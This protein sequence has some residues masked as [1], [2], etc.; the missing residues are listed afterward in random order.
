MLVAVGGGDLLIA[1]TRKPQRSDG[2]SESA[3]VDCVVSAIQQRQERA[4]MRTDGSAK[5]CASGDVEGS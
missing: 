4:S 2:A 1:M 5:L 3:V